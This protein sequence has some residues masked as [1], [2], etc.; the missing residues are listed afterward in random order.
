MNNSEWPATIKITEINGIKRPFL[1]R[2][3]VKSIAAIAT[4]KFA[5]EFFG[6][7]IDFVDKKKIAPYINAIGD[8]HGASS[9]DRSGKNYANTALKML[10]G[11]P[12]NH[13]LPPKEFFQKYGEEIK[14]FKPFLNAVFKILGPTPA[15]TA[16]TPANKTLLA[17]IQKTEKGTSSSSTI[18]ES[19]KQATEIG[20]D[21]DKPYQ[22]RARQA[23][24]ILV[25]YAKKEES[26][27]YNELAKKLNMPNPRNLNFVLGAV[28][29]ALNQLST[30]I[31]I[32]IPFIN[33]L[34]VN[35]DTRLPG[36]GVFE[37]FGV[38]K[39]EFIALSYVKQIELLEKYHQDIFLFDKWDLV[40]KNLDLKIQDNLP[41]E[42][43]E[44]IE[45]DLQQEALLE[46]GH[47]THLIKIAKRNP[48][49]R[50]ECLAHYGYDCQV[51]GFNFEEYGEIGKEY[52]QVHH[53]E[54]IC[55]K[56][57]E[58]VISPINDLIPVCANCH[59]MLHRKN[60]PYTVNELKEKLY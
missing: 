60:P 8:I 54:M 20:I 46:G 40:L 39:E 29:N 26:V 4:A 31:D 34:V 43:P 28:G 57:E 58:Y 50:L 2:K 55:D 19:T 18:K 42:T 1:N 51:C 25:E 53:K 13:L 33:T 41:A 16:N 5:C 32:E 11:E 9:H 35:S 38:S 3:D 15:H 30:V 7:E 44:G 47:N 23:L 12:D 6:W 36:E 49:A 21:G 59:V 45:P 14:A 24:P 37:F 56:D 17:A 48:K 22:Q 10:R 52:I 27:T